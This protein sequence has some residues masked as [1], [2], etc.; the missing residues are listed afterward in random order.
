MLLA[1]SCFKKD[2]IKTRKTIKLGTLYEYR[3]TEST[4]ILDADEGKYTFH[5]NLDGIVE[6]E[7]RWFNTIFQG[8]IGI[9]RHDHN[10]MIIGPMQANIKK[11]HIVS[12][13]TQGI[14]VKDSA[15]TIHREALN[16]FIFC[17]SLVR[18]THDA[19]GLFPN[20]D[21]YWYLNSNMAEDLAVELSTL[22]HGEILK[23]RKDGRHIVNPDISLENLNVYCRHEAVAYIP[24]EIH[25]NSSNTFTTEDFISKISDMSFVKP[26]SF[27]HE[28]EYRFSF[29]IVADNKI[30]P[31]IQDMVILNAE[32]VAKW[33]FTI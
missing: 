17:I 5:L 23:R 31:P 19:F 11:I 25:I 32:D 12:Q 15:A 10:P 21:D 30:L 24:R 4:Q 3:K 33:A 13:T 7:S 28:K 29:T 1:K 27:S 26:P 20:Y 2:N 22:L 18:K 14:K 8:I 6:V 9:G 16:C